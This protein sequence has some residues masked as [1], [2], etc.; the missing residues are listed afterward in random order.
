MQTKNQGFTLIELMIV[1]AI[2]GILA[3]VAIPA[4][5]NYVATSYGSQAM[6]GT[7]AVMAKVRGCIET[8]I[9]C[10]EVNAEITANTKLSVTPAVAENTDVTLTWTNSGC[11]L[12]TTV[13]ATGAITYSMAAGSTAS[14]GQCNDGAGL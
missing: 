13:A 10:T 5:R 11:V 6:G 8:G 9:D 7:S 3:A 4:Y 14:A 1:V 2:I 12:T